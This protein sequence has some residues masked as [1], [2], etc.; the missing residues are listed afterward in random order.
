M[1]PSKN[2]FDY[3]TEI[4]RLFPR[5]SE[6]EMEFRPDTQPTAY[7]TFMQSPYN[8]SLIANHS[9]SSADSISP[10]V[11]PHMPPTPPKNRLTENRS[12]SVK[13]A[14][15]ETPFSAKRQRPIVG[16]KILGN[17][18]YVN[19]TFDSPVQL[20]PVERNYEMPGWSE[21]QNISNT[22]TNRKVFLD[23]HNC[24]QNVFYELFPTDNKGFEF[25]TPMKSSP[26]TSFMYGSPV[27]P[28]STIS[29]SPTSSMTA[30][31][32]SPPS[33]YRRNINTNIVPSPSRI[34]QDIN[35]GKICTF[36]RKNGETPLVFMTHTVKEM[37]GNKNV[38]TCPILRSH[39]CATCGASGDDAHTM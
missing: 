34:N 7:N 11:F 13:H 4:N 18:D 10:E 35:P 33:P 19:P 16:R 2:M 6:N 12:Y 38:V 15:S 3:M 22:T 30:P 37:I 9:S 1:F 25:K 24:T 8:S 5:S 31:F 28:N 14:M 29:M 17:T 26:R 32:A 36:C 20:S 27:S 23:Q 39:V 21:Y